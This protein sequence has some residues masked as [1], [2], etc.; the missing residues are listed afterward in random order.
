MTLALQIPHYQR[1]PKTLVRILC[2][3]FDNHLMQMTALVKVDND[4]YN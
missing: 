1:L 3:R 2:D 4:I